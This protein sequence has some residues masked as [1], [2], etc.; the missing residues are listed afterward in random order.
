[1][2]YCR[3]FL[4]AQIDIVQPQVIIALGHATVSGLLGA[5]PNREMASLRGTWQLFETI[6]LICT[7]QPAYLLGNDT[8]KT[9]RMIWEDML[10]VMKKIGLPISEKQQHFFLP[11][12]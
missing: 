9:K 8:M 1:M 12:Q 2:E 3:P 10:K 4:K 6:P 5:E 11:K 7:F